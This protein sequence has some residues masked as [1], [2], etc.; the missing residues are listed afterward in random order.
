MELDGTPGLGWKEG[1]EVPA[2]LQ[3]ARGNQQPAS[4][5]LRLEAKRARPSWT[6]GRYVGDRALA[7]H[8]WSDHSHQF[9][10]NR[11]LGFL[12]LQMLEELQC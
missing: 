10:C 7:L 3:D 1:A 8:P 4:V 12:S 11:T 2:R 5:F 6:C 9:G